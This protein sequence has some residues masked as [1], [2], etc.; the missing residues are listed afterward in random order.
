[1]TGLVLRPSLLA[2]CTFL[3]IAC[4]SDETLPPGAD[5]AATT[6]DAPVTADASGGGDATGDGG[7]GSGDGGDGSGDGGDGSGDGGADLDA[8]G[9]GEPGITCGTEICD[10]DT[11]KCCVSQGVTNQTCIPAADQCTGTTIGCDGPEDCQG[12][13]ACCGTFSAGSVS[14]ACGAQSSC[15]FVLCNT[16]ND[17]PASSPMC[18]S[19]SLFP[20]ASICSQFCF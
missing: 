20:D 3:L 1:M 13:D 17:C 16:S 9:G 7:D 6:V 10:P 4:G 14:T 2:L 12:D 15:Q 18:C 5:D 8:G 11:H 19:S